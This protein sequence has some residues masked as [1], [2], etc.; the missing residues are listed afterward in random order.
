M[1]Y[2]P[3]PLN[4]SLA[5]YPRVLVPPTEDTWGNV[6]E[7]KL[8]VLSQLDQLS[9]SFKIS[10]ET[11]DISKMFDRSYIGDISEIVKT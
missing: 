9:F 11:F 5:S 4:P 10:K 1:G 7:E 2:I 3:I 8:Y 6:F